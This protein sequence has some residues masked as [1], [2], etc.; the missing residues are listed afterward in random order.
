MEKVKIR[1]TKP[2][3]KKK[4][5]IFLVRFFMQKNIFLPI[6]VS[7]IFA[8]LFCSTIYVFANPPDSPY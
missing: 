4:L 7:V 6:L 5:E 2:K 1:I 3:P 8:G